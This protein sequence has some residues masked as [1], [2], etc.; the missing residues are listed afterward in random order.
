MISLAG[1][2]MDSAYMGLKPH[3]LLQMF[4]ALSVARPPCISFHS[5]RRERITQLGRILT[6]GADKEER[7]PETA[8]RIRYRVQG[9]YA[10]S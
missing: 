5:R 8:L 10:A 2:L 7:N 4:L 3:V 1:Y 9:L 6:A